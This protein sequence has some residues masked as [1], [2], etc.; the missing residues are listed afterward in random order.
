M[1]HDQIKAQ[2]G[3]RPGEQCE[4]CGVPITAD[5]IVSNAAVIVHGEV[6]HYDCVDPLD[7]HVAEDS[8]QIAL[9]HA[10]STEGW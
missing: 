5:E 2:Y 8:A 10:R 9:D 6:Y 3:I 1:R 4:G 7:E